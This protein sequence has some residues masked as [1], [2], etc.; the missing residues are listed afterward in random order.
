MSDACVNLAPWI[1]GGTCSLMPQIHCRAKARTAMSSCRAIEVSEAVN[2]FLEFPKG[3][4]LFDLAF[5]D[6]AHLELALCSCHEE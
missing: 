3:E 5:S 4:V 1:K 2:P 6:K